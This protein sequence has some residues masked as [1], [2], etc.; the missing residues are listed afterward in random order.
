MKQTLKVGR[1]KAAALGLYIGKNRKKTIYVLMVVAHWQEVDKDFLKDFEVDEMAEVAKNVSVLV[2][3]G[4]V[5]EL[6]EE[7]RRMRFVRTR[8]LKVML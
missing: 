2:F 1:Q 7:R 6:Q 5:V 3:S 8:I 4:A